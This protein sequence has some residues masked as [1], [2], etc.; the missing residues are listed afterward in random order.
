[1][2]NF[3]LI[4]MQR[5]IFNVP[6]HEFRNFYKCSKMIAIEAL[7]LFGSSRVLRVKGSNA[8]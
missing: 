8:V 1:M 3:F 4:Q 2:D 5:I 6:S 7:T